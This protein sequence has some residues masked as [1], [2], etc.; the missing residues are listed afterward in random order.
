MARWALTLGALVILTT[1]TAAEART[2]AGDILWQSQLDVAGGR[3]G[4]QAVAFD[5]G[6]VVVA[7]FAQISTGS[8]MFVVRAHDAKTGVL[9]WEDRFVPDLVNSLTVTGL[10]IDGQRVVMSGTGFDATFANSQAVV[11]AY[12]P[13][14]GAVAWT[15]K[16]S[17]L[18]NG[19]AM[20]HTR[21]VV[22]AAIV[23]AAGGRHALVR[24]YAAKTGTVQW[25]ARPALPAGFARESGGRVA[26]HG[27]K[28][29]V[30]DIASKPAPFVDIVDGCLVR[31]YDLSD[32]TI[33][34]ESLH[35][36]SSFCDTTNVAADSQA[37][38]LSGRAGPGGD[39]YVALA[40]DADTGGFLWSHRADST[41][42]FDAAMAVDIER[43]IGFVIGWNF[44]IVPPGAGTVQREALL[45]RAYNTRTGV[46]QWEDR[47]LTPGNC[48]CHGLDVAVQN[49]RVFAFGK[50][51]Q[52]SDD[53]LVRVYDAKSGDLLWSNQ[54]T[55]APPGLFT[56]SAFG[57][58]TV[59][60]GRVFVASSVWNENGNEDFMVRAYDAK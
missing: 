45:L 2:D 14:T 47:Y 39:V 7:G 3:D 58:I 13:K 21:V 34:W 25:D 19:L 54:F 46:L 4:A 30:A 42:F 27:K 24:S 60:G 38:F 5:D 26:L 12:V 35:N 44:T 1:V 40:F 23:D 10:T 57:A 32:G 56:S 8:F 37:V 31:S 20:Q 33:L 6:R 15:D 17:G 36:E 11:R 22:A 18:A 29:F 51:T 52:G 9:L 16:W 55:A 41:P 28:A 49:G 43:H 48:F 50:T 59:G 53:W